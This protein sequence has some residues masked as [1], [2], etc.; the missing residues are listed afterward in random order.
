M[1]LTD[2]TI[3]YSN[4]NGIKV[5]NHRVRHGKLH[6]L[7]R[8][9]AQLRRT[10]GES[11]HEL[12]WQKPL[13]ILRRYQFTS[14]WAPVPFNDPLLIDP[15]QLSV[16]HETLERVV[17]TF[18]SQ[19]KNFKKC[20]DLLQGLYDDGENPLLDCMIKILASNNGPIDPLLVLLH[21]PRAQETISEA[22]KFSMSQ[23]EI[24]YR[25]IDI[26][27][28]PALKS[29][30]PAKTM[31]L[32]GP[33]S[34][35]EKRSYVFSSPKVDY[36]HTINYA[37]YNDRVVTEKDFNRSL[38]GPPQINNDGY[39]MYGKEMETEVIEKEKAPSDPVLE[40]S[41]DRPEVPITEAEVT[42]RF[43]L[44][45]RDTGV[46]LEDSKDKWLYVINPHKRGAIEDYDVSEFIEKRRNDRV[47]EGDYLIL[48]YKGTGDYIPD[49]ADS[50]LGGNA[51]RMRELQELWKGRLRV[52]VDESSTLEVSLELLDLGSKLAN[53]NNLR[54][55]M[56]SDKSKIKTNY[57]EDFHA[58]MT[59][60][61]LE[62][63]E[64]E[65]WDN[66]EDIAHAHKNAGQQIRHELFKAMSSVNLLELEKVGLIVISLDD[67]NVGNLIIIRVV[68]LTESRQVMPSSILPFYYSIKD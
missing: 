53:E 20:C 37:W 64:E 24:P 39:A 28:A 29:L 32:F 62:E 68:D 2:Q 49:Y 60:V 52:L 27:T 58:I 61:G 41:S 40:V 21:K 19:E 66:A 11:E 45:E 42:A 36:F 56:S 48:R 67:E 5:K 25:E 30:K 23:G 44:L 1:E 46:W 59:L 50:I 12:F 35:Y 18:P 26:V 17:V 31:L 38:G 55:W 54:N 9:I 3:L 47:E 51:G 14:I 13:R 34:L 22:I 65:L 16:L 57:R 6:L 43:F 7:S 10:L 4:C 15:V 8:S 33:V 63:R